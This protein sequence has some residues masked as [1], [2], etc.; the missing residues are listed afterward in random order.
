MLLH[1]MRKLVRKHEV[2]RKRYSGIQPDVIVVSKR[3]RVHGLGPGSGV[4]PA[5]HAH[6]TQVP[7]EAGFEVRSQWTRKG[8]PTLS[9]VR[10]RRTVRRTVARCSVRR[11]TCAVC[12]AFVDGARRCPSLLRYM[13][14]LV[15]K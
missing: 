11:R 12:P 5:M 7:P 3:I 15:G 1:Y 9:K 14:E 6:T 8:F 13:H 10:R 4:C 2:A